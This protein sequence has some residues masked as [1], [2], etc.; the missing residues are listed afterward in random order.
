MVKYHPLAYI[1]FLKSPIE[2]ANQNLYS[3]LKIAGTANSPAATPPDKEIDDLNI[4]E[5]A[6]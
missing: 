5:R 1:H 4:I 2:C 3:V 6:R